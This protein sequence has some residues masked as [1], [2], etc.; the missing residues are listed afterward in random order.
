MMI[1]AVTVA[2][3]G[4]VASKRVTT[5]ASKYRRAAVGYSLAA[6]LVVLAIPWWRPLLPGLG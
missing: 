3:L 5:D 4:S 1:L 2:H 6:L